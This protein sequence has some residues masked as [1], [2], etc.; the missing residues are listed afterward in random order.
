MSYV[1]VLENLAESKH[2]WV[3]RSTC[4]SDQA[5]LTPA[6]RIEDRQFLAMHRAFAPTGGLLTGDQ[7]ANRMRRHTEQPISALARRIV[8]RS[9]LSI[10]WESQIL[11]P[12]FQLEPSDLSVRPVVHSVIEELKA[13]F[14]DWELA[15]W[16]A[17]PNAWLNDIV[18]VDLLAQRPEAVL[19]AA[20]TDRFVAKG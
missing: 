4:R 19:V 7:L 12:G 13:V 2:D 17:Q 16:F 6:R 8:E 10:V 11:L 3:L 15:L 1:A 18:P 9:V 5:K 14:D 20:R